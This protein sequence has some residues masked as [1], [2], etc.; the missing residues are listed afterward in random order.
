MADTIIMNTSAT[1]L[2]RSLDHR[3]FPSI[4]SELGGN[5]E[6]D[7]YEQRGNIIAKMIMPGI[8]P[9]NLDVFVDEDTIRVSG[10]RR[11]EKETRDKNYINKEVHRESF[12]RIIDLAKMVDASKASG[13]YK[14]GI[15]LVTMPVMPYTKEK[16]MRVNIKK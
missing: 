15:L 11:E 14:N 16:P 10:Q 7:L 12:S 13:E 1:E 4:P 5:L 6:I 2:D 3:F 8:N 9:D